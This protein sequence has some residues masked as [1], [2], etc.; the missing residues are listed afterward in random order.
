MDVLVLID[1]LDD[2]VHNAKAVPLTDQ[3]RIDREEI[4]DI[5]DQMRAT[6][7]EE[8]KQ[9]RWIVKERQEMLAEAKREA[10]RVIKEARD[11][12]QRLVS[13][14]EITKQA[15]RAAEEARG[16]TATPLRDPPGPRADE[17]VTG[18]DGTF[19]FDDLP[20]GDRFVVHASAPERTADLAFDVAAPPEE[21]VELRLE[22]GARLF[23]QVV[24]GDGAPRARQLV[25]LTVG[26][27]PY[28]SDH[29]STDET[30]RF[31][32]TGLAEGAYRLYLDYKMED[33]GHG[34]FEVPAGGEVGPLRLVFEPG[35][36]L[37]GRVLRPDGTPAG[38]AQ[39]AFEIDSAGRNLRHAQP[40]E[41]DGTFRLEVPLEGTGRVI[42]THP[43]HG[44]AEAPVE[45]R[46]GV[47]PVEL[48]LEPTARIAGRVIAPDD[49]AVADAEV[50]LRSVGETGMSTSTGA[51]PDGSFA[52]TPG[53]GEYR[54]MATAPGWVVVE[55]PEVLTLA[56]SRSIEGI[57]LELERGARI[58]GRIT[59][60][61]PDDL[62]KVRVM[63]MSRG[64]GPV[65]NPAATVDYQ[66]R[67]R[68]EGITPGRWHV[69]ASLS[70]PTRQASGDVSL[71]V[72]QER[73]ELDL[74]FTDGYTLS[75][76]VRSWGEPVHGSVRLQGGGT[77]LGEMTDGRGGFRFA[78]LPAGEYQL[79]VYLDPGYYETRELT[80]V[81]DEE[82]VLDLRPARVT[83]RLISPGGEPVAGGQVLLVQEGLE[84]ARRAT[85]QATTGPDGSFEMPGVAEGAYRLSAH[86]GGASVVRSVQVA[87]RETDLGEIW[88]SAGRELTLL[89]RLSGGGAPQ[90]LAVL[91]L[92]AGD[93]LLVPVEAAVGPDGLAH[94]RGVPEDAH[95]A[96]VMAQ[97][98][99]PEAVAQ[100]PVPG[101]LPPE[102]PPIPVVLEQMGTLSIHLPEDVDGA[103][104]T[105]VDAAGRP[106]LMLRL[107]GVASVP[108]GRKHQELPVE[109]GTWTLTATASDGRAWS[110]QARVTPAQT[111]EVRLGTP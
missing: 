67:Y 92:D 76:L 83:G 48:V 12:Q 52:F 97:E 61:E 81:T 88:L 43:E 34:P 13:Q 55:H 99:S 107:S 5:L 108:L 30:G 64:S 10:E 23:G 33:P 111:T 9:A 25:R 63:G 80:L 40:V 24:D 6:I 104:L 42:A 41:A 110:A 20:T 73:A 82:L 17:R 58:E 21:P 3:V 53:P 39:V 72:G 51:R 87:G 56:E 96:V 95:T 22:P 70:A 27:R 78:G 15:E 75:G 29:V 74:E 100:L 89:P 44:R 14:E 54:L 85:P 86:H 19:R 109:P 66:G 38:G 1:K 93:R 101:S 68:L 45:L 65:T 79:S 8:I 59:G 49:T 57:V 32:F 69:V 91:F 16:I 103:T 94:V 102:A 90:R 71:A 18:Q 98:P 62:A 4:Y 77:T 7:P 37:E 31:E 106:P 50:H 35:P 11:Q 28:P 26:P 2:L 84:A 47:E 46:P 60:L 36:V 105:L